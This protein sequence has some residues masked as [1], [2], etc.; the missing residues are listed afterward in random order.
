MRTTIPHLLPTVLMGLLH[1][2]ISCKQARGQGI[3]L[4][5]YTWRPPLPPIPG[6]TQSHSPAQA[7]AGD[8]DTVPASTVPDRDFAGACRPACSGHM[9][10]GHAV[11]SEEESLSMWV[12]AWPCQLAGRSED[13]WQPAAVTNT[14]TASGSTG[15]ELRSCTVI[16][17]YRPPSYCKKL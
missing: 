16:L 17:A 2:R 12:P 14:G 1:W 13:G 10:C 5:W 11:F 9:G 8:I 7:P 15:W 4:L 3:D 6:W